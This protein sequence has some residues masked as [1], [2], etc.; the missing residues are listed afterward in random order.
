[1]PYTLKIFNFYM[2][3]LEKNVSTAVEFLYTRTETRKIIFSKK[4]YMYLQNVTVKCILHRSIY[5]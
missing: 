5:L 3:L 2:Y 4:I 1:M